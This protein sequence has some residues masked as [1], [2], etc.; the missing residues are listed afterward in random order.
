MNQLYIIIAL[1]FKEGIEINLF[2]FGFSIANMD[3]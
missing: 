3:K 1:Q 2:H